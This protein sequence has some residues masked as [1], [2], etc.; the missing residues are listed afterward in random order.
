M[1]IVLVS[2]STGMWLKTFEHQ[3][4]LKKLVYTYFAV[5]EIKDRLRVCKNTRSMVF[6][7]LFG[8]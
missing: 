6:L 7:A 8:S 5:K 4:V 2:E 1:S 3:L